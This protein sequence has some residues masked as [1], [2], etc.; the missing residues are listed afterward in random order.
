MDNDEDE[1]EDEE[2]ILKGSRWPVFHKNAQSK[3]LK[4]QHLKTKNLNDDNVGY[5]RIKTDQN[6]KKFKPAQIP[7]QTAHSRC[8]KQKKEAGSNNIQFYLS[9]PASKDSSPQPDLINKL[10]ITTAQ[11]PQI[12]DEE[13]HSLIKSQ[14]DTEANTKCELWIQNKVDDYCAAVS[15]NDRVVHSKQQS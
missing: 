11:P 3:A 1:D 2:D 6:S 12:F 7:K 8:V 14:S 13:E 5:Q 9:Q 4:L 10:N 15:N